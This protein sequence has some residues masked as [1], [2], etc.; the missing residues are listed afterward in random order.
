MS[1]RKGVDGVFKAKMVR[2][3]RML[4]LFALAL[5]WGP[6]AVDA[7]TC[8]HTNKQGPARVIFAD[9][10]ISKAAKKTDK[11][12]V[13]RQNSPRQSETVKWD[14]TPGEMKLFAQLVHA[15]ASGEPYSGKVAV[16][17]TVLNRIHDKNYPDNLK[18]VIFQLES[19]HCQYSPVRDGRIWQEAD[20]SAWRAIKDALEGEDPTGGATSFYNPRKTDDRWVRRQPVTNVI[21]NHVFF[22][23]R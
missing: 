1:G 19:G 17:A 7:T 11:S 15:E 10:L 9:N 2:W 12:S 8:E 14:L 3:L 6:P 18:G 13:A 16:A 21:G 5:A 23:S 22:K 20:Q 4:A